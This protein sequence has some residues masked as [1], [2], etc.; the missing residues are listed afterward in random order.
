MRLWEMKCVL[1]ETG[2]IYV[3]CDWHAS[4]YIKCEMDKI[5]GYKNFVNEVIWCYKSG[6]ASPNTCFS[7]KHDVLLFYVKSSNYFFAPQK[8]KSYNR[9][10]KSYH[11]IGIH[12]FQ[13]EIG[14]YTIVGM[15]DYWE[16]DMVGRT[17][18]ERLS[19][20]TQKPEAL[21]ERIIK[22]SSNEGDVVAD[23]FCGSGTTCAVAMKHNRH[24]IGCDS[25]PVAITVTRDRLV[26]V[27]EEISGMKSNISTGSVPFEE[28]FQM[29]EAVANV[30]NIEILCLKEGK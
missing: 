25:S 28:K 10:F 8:E 27:G 15:K 22:A 7:R 5:F 4:H 30:P 2:S 21:L 11:F 23:F 14:W 24:F 29:T 1:K 3:H 12:E 16:L 13:D 9:D 6:G 19:Y 18:H 17:S 26:K 20:P